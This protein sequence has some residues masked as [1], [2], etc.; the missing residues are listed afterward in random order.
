M[1]TAEIQTA[2]FEQTG[3]KTSVKKLTGS[4]KHWTR[5]SPMLQ[6]GIHPKYPFE[7]RQAFKA[8]FAGQTFADDYSLEILTTSFEASEPIHY[9]K[10]HKPKTIEQM[11]VRQW[12]SAN[13]QMRLD[14]ATARNA[15][16]LLTGN[17]ARYY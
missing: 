9:K 13:S 1:N 17:V 7:W 4:M 5:F 10:E 14:K 6:G 15:K 8:T 3:I 11:S 16:R 12:G 2:I